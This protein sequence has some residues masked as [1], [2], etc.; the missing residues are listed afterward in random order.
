MIDI[1][2]YETAWKDD[3]LSAVNSVH[4][5]TELTIPALRQ[6][7]D[8]YTRIK[9]LRSDDFPVQ[10]IANRHRTRLFSFGI[11]KKDTSKIFK[12]S[13]TIIIGD[14][15]ATMNEAVNRGILPIEVDPRSKFVRQVEKL[16][17]AV[18]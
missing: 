6:A 17:E 1:P 2:H 8:I 4:L 15:W 11:G 13:N 10:V 5:V 7:K 18:R 12:Q 3:L 9:K 14:D 16:A